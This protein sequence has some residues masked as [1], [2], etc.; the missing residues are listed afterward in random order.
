M[1]SLR[2]HA[3]TA[4]LRLKARAVRWRTWQRC[5]GHGSHFA[6]PYLAA[7]FAADLRALEK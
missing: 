7:G 6:S 2:I 1:S 3:E 4:N 5:A